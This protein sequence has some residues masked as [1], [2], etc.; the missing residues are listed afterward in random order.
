MNDIKVG[1]GWGSGGASQF[2]IKIEDYSWRIKL[3]Y[4]HS[5]LPEKAH[6]NDMGY[7]L[8]AAETVNIIS[9]DT[10]LISVGI[11]CNFP[12][13]TGAIIKDRSSVATKRKLF[14]VAGVIDNGY[15]GEIKVAL[16]NS[17]P[18][19]VTIISGEKI[20]QLLLVPTYSAQNIK[21]V[22]Q[23]DVTSRNN[24]GFGSSG[25]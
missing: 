2:P 5:R 22:D 18:T 13:F 6:S 16:Y 1:S 8:F 24:S 7:D 17:N 23:L 25:I 11:A 4:S 12:P 9:H 14:T 3:L 19:E 15:T 10:A 20:A 21:I